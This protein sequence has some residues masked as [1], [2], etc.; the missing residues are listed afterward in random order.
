MV[1]TEGSGSEAIMRTIFGLESPHLGS[2]S[3]KG[4]KQFRHTAPESVALG[5][6]YVPRERKVEGIVGAMSLYENITLSQLDHFSR[7]GIIDTPAERRT[8]ADWVAKLS[9]K[10]PSVDADCAN[11]S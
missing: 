10:T 2:I 4:E 9:I 7:Y 5:L 6:A 11:L 8:A 3:I 1:G